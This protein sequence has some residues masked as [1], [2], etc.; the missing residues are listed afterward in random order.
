MSLTSSLQLANNSLIASQVGLQ[1]VGQNIAN[2]NT[3]GYVREEMRLTPAPTQR[4]GG[5]LLGMGVQVT[6]IVQQIDK[7]LEGR[8]RGAISDSA[9]ADVEQQTY[10]QLEGLVGELSDTDLSTSMN[11]FFNSISEVLN[12]P[13]DVSI[14]NLA[15][16]QGQTLAGDIRRLAGRAQQMVRDLDAQV[17]N[18]A[19]D[20]N[21]LTK[22]IADLNVRISA[23][24]GGD[25]TP[26]DAVGLR[27]Q[28]LKALSDLSELVQ[29][30]V[31][32]QPNGTVSVFSGGDYLVLEGRHREMKAVDLNVGG[33]P[34]SEVRL[35]ATNA[36]L[37][38][39]GGKL[40]GL[41][42]ARDKIVGGFLDDLNG[43]ARTLAFEFNKVF[44]GGQGLTG[45]D[46]L[47]GEFAVD[48]AD[49][50]LDA[51]G[52]TYAPVNG[53]FNVLTLNEQTGLTQT[54][55][56]RVD[57]NG[58]DEDTSLNDLAA[59]LDAVDGLSAE[60]TPT[61]KLH[62]ESDAP[63]TTFA[64]DH[65]TSGVLA[66]LGLNTF[67]SGDSATNLNVNAVV[68]DDPTKFAASAGGVGEDADNAVQLA[69]FL[70]RP[71]E[72]AD[73]GTLTFLYDQ[74]T[75][76][77]TQASTVAT[78]VADG[79]RSFR[80]TLEGQKMS[81]SGVSL[82]EEAVRMMTYQRA[83]QASA[84]YIATISDLM[85]VLVNL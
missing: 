84:R 11:N 34:K 81:V 58:F 25:T 27:D 44:A 70:D 30:D 83:Y 31:R 12:Q 66:A 71:L 57:L 74:M 47:T 61:G 28:R 24:E 53:A 23:I 39:S 52:L 72:T 1:V 13:A 5:L 17:V 49:A 16:L 73:G 37:K 67:F 78:S 14:R 38:I 42:N 19:Q 26:S 55:T 63:D 2:A 35:A 43:F 69:A 4:H 80:Q 85:E 75:S 21:R 20:I 64:F 8:L 10:L 56:I 36:P 54:T 60:V 65:D 41:T 46:E 62:L 79:L 22:T 68:A 76:K 29:I 9:S 6:A 18:S 59:A 51:A 32:E 48:D 33:L 3:P 45:F 40:V 50:S 7:F 82:D 77:L 15:V